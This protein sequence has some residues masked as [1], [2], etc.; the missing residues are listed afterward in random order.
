[1]IS[2]F[3]SSIL[4]CFPVTLSITM[5]PDWLQEYDNAQY[6]SFTVDPST[7]FMSEIRTSLGNKFWFRQPIGINFLGWGI[8][9]GKFRNLEREIGEFLRKLYSL[10]GNIH[11]L[12]KTTKSIQYIVVI[13][14]CDKDRNLQ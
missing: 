2:C 12:G 5:S 4:L 14:I 3:P 10:V 7:T 11:W 9:D 13:S 1:M 8:F 6:P